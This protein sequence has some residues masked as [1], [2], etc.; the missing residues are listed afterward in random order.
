MIDQILDLSKCIHSTFV[1]QVLPKPR[2]VT[3]GKLWI[4]LTFVLFVPLLGATI[5]IVTDFLS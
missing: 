2:E 4:G 1:S 5:Q 3:F